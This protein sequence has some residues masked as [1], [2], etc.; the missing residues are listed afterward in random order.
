MIEFISYL[1]VSF[2]LL[3]VLYII[4]LCAEILFD[5]SFLGY[6]ENLKMDTEKENIIFFKNLV[7]TEL[8][9]KL[10][11]IGFNKWCFLYFDK[12]NPEKFC[13]ELDKME[14]NYKGNHKNM[15]FVNFNGS[16]HKVSLPE[17]ETAF[18]WFREQGYIV[19]IAYD[20]S[21]HLRIEIGYYYEII[22]NNTIVK[23]NG[24]FKTYEIA[25][26]NCLRELIEIYEKQDN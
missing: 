4:K 23:F 25:R 9:E 2:I 21:K 8:A 10:K 12:R 19:N 16:I 26:E 24:Y 22:F 14:V 1:S 15:E 20:F 11:N 13:F 6:I 17:Y 18:N 7:T 3:V 5:K